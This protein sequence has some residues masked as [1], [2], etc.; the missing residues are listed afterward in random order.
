M[1]T[2][3]NNSSTEEY[4]QNEL[5]HSLSDAKNIAKVTINSYDTQS[6]LFHGYTWPGWVTI[7]MCF[8]AALANL[9][10]VCIH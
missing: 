5:N 3:D 6:E 1:G 10:H 2:M 7:L 8:L 4:G 9:F